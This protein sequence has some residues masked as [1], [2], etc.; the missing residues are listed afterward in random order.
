MKREEPVE[1]MGNYMGKNRTFK[2][3]SSGAKDGESRGSTIANSVSP[4]I[5][6]I[7]SLIEAQ[8]LLMLL[9]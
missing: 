3:D 4:N 6:V 8:Q 9:I 1:K 2:R 5:I 7:D